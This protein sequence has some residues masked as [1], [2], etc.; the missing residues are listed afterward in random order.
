MSKRTFSVVWF[1]VFAVLASI[2]LYVSAP[3]L[4]VT[5]LDRQLMLSVESRDAG[6]TRILLSKGANPNGTYYRSQR[7]VDAE[8]LL[9]FAVKNHDRE[10]LDALLDGGARINKSDWLGRTALMF[11]IELQNYAL[12]S[13]LLDRGA[14]PAIKDRHGKTAYDRLQNGVQ[15]YLGLRAK[16]MLSASL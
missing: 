10:N 4:F 9:S 16:L 11:A 12:A 14:D 1:F 5:G 13:Y 7:Y 6:R 8:P 3:R 15:G 2:G